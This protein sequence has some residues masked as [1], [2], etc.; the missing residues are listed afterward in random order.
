MFIAMFSNIKY[1]RGCVPTLTRELIE[2][3]NADN[4][5]CEFEIEE[6]DQDAL[7]L[8]M[9]MESIASLNSIRFAQIVDELMVEVDLLDACILASGCGERYR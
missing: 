3:R 4:T 9:T 2:D 7:I 8:A 6:S 5:R 1:Q